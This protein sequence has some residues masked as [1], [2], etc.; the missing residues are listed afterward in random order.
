MSKALCPLLMLLLLCS[1]CARPA[2]GEDCRIPWPARRTGEPSCWIRVPLGK[3]SGLA[4]D[5]C[6]EATEWRR[7]LE[8]PAPGCLH[9]EGPARLIRPPTLDLPA[10]EVRARVNGKLIRGPDLP[11]HD[12]LAFFMVRA[13]ERQ[14]ER[15]SLAVASRDPSGWL[16]GWI[17]GERVDSVFFTLGFV[18]LLT[19]AG[20]HLLAL[21]RI[22]GRGW[23]EVP[24]YLWIWALSGWRWG[25]VRPIAL[26]TFQR[27]IHSSGARLRSPLPL[28]LVIGL[29][30]CLFRLESGG[31]HYLAA[32]WGGAWG[33]RKWGGHLGMALGSWLWVV[34]L[35]LFHDRSMSLLTPVLSLMTIPIAATLLFPAALGVVILGMG[36]AP[37]ASF[38][39]WLLK[40]WI[41]IS[42]L[43]G[44]NWV[45]PPPRPATQSPRIIQLNV[46]QGDAALVLERGSSGMVDVGPERA[47]ASSS[48]LSLFSRHGVTR[49]DWMVLTHLDEDHWGGLRRIAPW[50][51]IG[52]V[53]APPAWAGSAKASELRDLSRRWGFRV[54]FRPEGCFPHRWAPLEGRVHRGRL[55]ANSGMVGVAIPGARGFYLNLGDASAA[56]AEEARLWQALGA[57]LPVDVLKLSHHGSR[58]STEAGWLM[59]LS[60]RQAWIS[61]G[62]ANRYG[63]PHPGVLGVLERQGVPW[64]GTWERGGIH[65]P[66]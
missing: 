51:P 48:W 46:G 21:S 65:Y 39:S 4:T 61:A 52:C 38:S 37:L 40:L 24:L 29:E 35:Q 13:I 57:P 62:F 50:I 3:D 8:A 19:T 6:I 47:A 27:L 11:S 14:R 25:L 15:F 12:R 55:R 9:V 58:T 34:P 1:S 20:V 41:P 49:L 23:W 60:P 32:V 5:A 17:V 42:M 16:R 59:R 45:V 53:V 7:W 33:M 63:H 56:R 64:I 18:H 30:A 31:L 26:I 10:A 54:Q 2:A 22:V 43:P 66:E 36:A 28:L 44:M